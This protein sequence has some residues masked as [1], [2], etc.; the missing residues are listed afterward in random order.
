VAD[1]LHMQAINSIQTLSIGEVEQLL[2]TFRSMAVHFPIWVFP[3]GASCIDCI[4]HKP[5]VMLAMLVA[6]S[7]ANERLQAACD[8][9]FRNI[10][11][12]KVIVEGKR[13]LE[14]LQGLLIYLAWHHHYM[15]H[16]TQQIYQ[17]LQL[18]IGMAVDLGLNKPKSKQRH[19]PNLSQN[20]MGRESTTSE[21][22]TAEEKR[23]LLG[24][25]ALS[26]GL[27]VL[28]FDKPQNLAYT[29]HLRQ[30]G[31][32]LAEHGCCDTDRDWLPTIE[33]LHI[34]E[35]IQRSS[36]TDLEATT[37]SDIPRT[38]V[39]DAEQLLQHWK[40]RSLTGIRDHT[41]LSLAFHFVQI[42]LYEKA[43]SEE[44]ALQS[45]L[46]QQAETAS[47]RISGAPMLLLSKLHATQAF[48]DD[49]LVKPASLLR[50]MNIVE[51]T[52][53]ITATITL[54]RLSRLEPEQT[55]EAGIEHLQ[56]KIQVDTYILT[57]C[58]RMSDLGVRNV[59]YDASGLFSW[60]KAIAQGIRLWV[61]SPSESGGHDHVDAESLANPLA[62]FE[63]LQNLTLQ[64]GSNQQ[65]S[66]PTQA[67]TADQ[68]HEGE[69]Q[70]SWS[71]GYEM[72]LD[73]KFW[74]T[75]ISNWPDITVPSV[76]WK[77]CC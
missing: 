43:L 37:A 59:Q 33:L 26:C 24:C 71:D 72:M 11:A 32:D 64:N 67:H 31:Q 69:T 23:A 55:R 52:H 13:S 41:R 40:Y 77:R 74:D 5:F 9:A 20:S 48:L 1:Y 56:I 50:N 36:R 3:E 19:P 29:D 61:S 39:R 46:T 51:W 12:R 35:E 2:V 27:A 17:Y 28:G 10:L 70:G 7:S 66:S 4:K 49:I 15:R 25:Y 34:A 6:S 53:L 60:F 57:L 42:Y 8:I 44:Q 62:T 68:G 21:G 63:T 18:A 58:E 30:C 22:G 65:P 45:Q 14:L 75:F 73:D 47:T 54:A 76:A 16:E 38:Y